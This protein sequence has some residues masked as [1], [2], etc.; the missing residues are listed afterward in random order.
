MGGNHVENIGV[1]EIPTIE[2]SSFV[3]LHASFRTALVLTLITRICDS[4]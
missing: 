3:L 2:W 1:V 4:R